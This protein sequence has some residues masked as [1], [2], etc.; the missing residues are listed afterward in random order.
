MRLD[1]RRLS[2]P[3]GGIFLFCTIRDTNLGLGFSAHLALLEAGSTCS[4]RPD[5]F[6]QPAGVSIE[7]LT[8]EVLTALPMY[9]LRDATKWYGE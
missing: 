6:Y 8:D 2:I 5:V 7:K 4:I 1:L 9:L 3:K